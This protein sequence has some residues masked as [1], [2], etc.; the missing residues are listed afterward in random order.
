M[1]QSATNHKHTPLLLGLLLS[2]PMMFAF[3]IFVM[4]PFYDALCNITGL[5]GKVTLTPALSPTDSF[6]AAN[7]L[8]AANNSV[9]VQLLTH[10]NPKMPWTFKTTERS[11]KVIPGKPHKTQFKVHNPTNKK[12]IAQAIPSISPPE[13]AQYVKKMECFCFN[14]QTLEAGETQFMPMTF[15]LTKDIPKH[16]ETI[17]ISYTLFD[18]TDRQA[19]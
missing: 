7:P 11:V 19:S 8:S 6:S 2:V 18:V 14:H 10:N 9:K 15:Y 4:P 12:M 5:N 16:L 13:G 3:A 17:T 1:T